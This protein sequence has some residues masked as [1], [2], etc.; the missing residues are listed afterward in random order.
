MSSR[1]ELDADMVDDEQYRFLSGVGKVR[2]AHEEMAT[3][4]PEIGTQ[5]LN[6]PM[7]SHYTTH[8]GLTTPDL[9]TE[10]VHETTPIGPASHRPRREPLTSED[11][12][13]D[14]AVHNT[15][16]NISQRRRD[17]YQARH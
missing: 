8:I 10:L 17:T 1:F 3:G 2:Q 11:A 12:D 4:T 15:L 13:I 6:L 5:Q 14:N 9:Q 16:S 7:T